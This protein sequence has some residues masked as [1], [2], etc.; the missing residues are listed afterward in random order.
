MKPMNSGPKSALFLEKAEADL[1][2]DEMEYKHLRFLFASAGS[3]QETS[4]ASSRAGEFLALSAR[5]DD[6]S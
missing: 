4:I 2:F 6:G 1:P 3:L 5:F